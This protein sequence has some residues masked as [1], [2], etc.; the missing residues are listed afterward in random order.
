[1]IAFIVAAAIAAVAFFLGLAYGRQQGIVLVLLY[2]KFLTKRN[3]K[4]EEVNYA[5]DYWLKLRGIDPES[6]E[7]KAQ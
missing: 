3:A 6:V 1:M 4:P 2:F 7:F 5:V